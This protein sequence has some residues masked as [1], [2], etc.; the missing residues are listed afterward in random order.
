M[1]LFGEIRHA[2]RALC[3][4]P[5]FFATAVLTLTLGI[6]ALTAILTVYDAVLLKPRASCG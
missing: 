6:G 3:A 1:N 5:G 4:K 2:W